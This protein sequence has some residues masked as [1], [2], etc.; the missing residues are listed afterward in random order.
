[1]QMNAVWFFTLL[2]ILAKHVDSASTSSPSKAQPVTNPS[3]APK[4]SAN[5]GGG[6]GGG[7]NVLSRDMKKENRVDVQISEPS[8]SDGTPAVLVQSKDVETFD[9][10]S[11]DFYS[12]YAMTCG[13][14]VK[15]IPDTDGIARWAQEVSHFPMVVVLILYSSNFRCLP[16]ANDIVVAK[17]SDKVTVKS[18]KS[19]SSTRMSNESF[20][21]PCFWWECKGLTVWVD[22]RHITWSSSF[23]LVPTISLQVQSGEL[24]INMDPGCRLQLTKEHNIRHRFQNKPKTI[25]EMMKKYPGFYLQPSHPLPRRLYRA[26]NTLTL[27]EDLQRGRDTLKMIECNAECDEGQ[28]FFFKMD[29]NAKFY[30]KIF[31]DGTKCSWMKIC[32]QGEQGVT[33]KKFYCSDKDLMNVY[34]QHGFVVMPGSPNGATIRLTKSSGANGDLSVQPTQI[35]VDFDGE[36]FSVWSVGRERVASTTKYDHDG[37]IILY[38]SHHNCLI[39]NKGIMHM[40]LQN[41]KVYQIDPKKSIDNVSTGKGAAVTYAPAP[42]RGTL[43]SI[44]AKCARKFQETKTPDLFAVAVPTTTKQNQLQLLFNQ[45]HSALNLLR[46]RTGWLIWMIFFG[47]FMGSATALIIA[48]IILYFMRRCVYADWYRGMYKRYGCDASGITGGVTGSQFGTNSALNLLRGR[49]GWLIWM[50]FFGFF[51]GSATALIIAGII[52]YFMRRSI[53]ADWYRGMYKR[54][55]CDASGIT[56]GVT[57]SQ[58][59]TTVTGTVGTTITSSTYGGTTGSTIGTTGSTIGTTGSTI[60]TT[61]ST[62]GTTG[63]TIGTTA[64]SV[65]TT[66]G[67]GGTFS[68]VSRNDMVTM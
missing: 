50:I 35:G 59:G 68:A 30:S 28:L 63:S 16:D 4:A 57:G 29:K 51:M 62:I 53:Y 2:V 37:H 46:G 44:K 20:M 33:K 56:G 12:P 21:T 31:V 25:R 8:I 6:G 26:G 52:L 14:A 41:G 64:T 39:K 48:G 23:V 5:G 36:R 47:F 42:T 17:E 15:A 32:L 22:P 38:F 1:M 43:A 27:G 49:T 19:R 61:G 58:F 40:G 54:Y 11:S 7:S 66:G 3:P 13:E 18:C 10:H 45:N 34:V 55:G 65:S 60:G 67:T 24:I 9:K